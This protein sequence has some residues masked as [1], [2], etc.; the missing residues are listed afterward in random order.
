M[1]MASHRVGRRG[2]RLKASF[3]WV[4][5]WFLLSGSAVAGEVSRTSGVEEVPQPGVYHYK[6]TLGAEYTRGD[7]GGDGN[8]DELYI[9]AS[10]KYRGQTGSVQVTVPWMS[11]KSS[12]DT[13]LLDGGMAGRGNMNKMLTSG[14]VT[15]SGLGDVILSATRFDI[16]G[17]HRSD[18]VVDLTGKVEFGTADETAGLGTGEN[19]YAAQLDVYRA[20]GTEMVY[21]Y[22]GYKLRGDPP[23]LNLNN[24]AYGLV[25]LDHRFS[26]RF[27]GG[28]DV[29]VEQAALPGGD[30]AVETGIYGG[31]RPSPSMYWLAYVTRGYTDAS[32]DWGVG[33]SVSWMY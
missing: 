29:R 20:V 10:F 18:L 14:D 5:L 30:A 26:D 17:L 32:P 9:P 1:T 31:F 27:S 4:A 24:T 23:G 13:L 15:E 21:G 19:D 7:Y 6:F 8:I 2:G 12:G 3:L 11:V 22:L 16:L 28:A 25:G 33:T